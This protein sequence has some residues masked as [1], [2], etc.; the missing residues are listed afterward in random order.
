MDLLAYQQELDA[1]YRPLRQ[2][3]L[4]QNEGF[5]QL[6]EN[7]GQEMDEFALLHPREPGFALKAELHARI[8]EHFQPVIFRNSPFFFEMGLRPAEN[9]GTPARMPAAWLLSRRIG[10]VQDD[11]LYRNIRGFSKEEGGLGLAEWV[12]VFDADHHS[13]GTTRLLQTGINGLLDEVR[14]EKVGAGQAKLAYLDAVEKSCESV[15]R[16][17]S[18]FADKAEAMVDAAE[19]ARGAESLSGQQP[20]AI[21]SGEDELAYLRMIAAAARRVPAEPPRTFYEGLAMLWFL[22]EVTASIEGIGI[23]VIGSPDRQL[24]GLYLADLAGGRLTEEQARDLIAHWMLPTDVKF[25]VQDSSWPETSTCIELGGCDEAGHPLY[26]ELTRLFIQVH[27]ANHFL[28]PK[29]NCRISADATDA[30]LELIGGSVLRGHNH[31]ALLNDDV[32]IPAIIRSGKTLAEARRYVNG[33]C[34]ETIVEGVEHSAGAYYYFNMA[35][36]LDLCFQPPLASAE[37]L[38]RYRPEGD[39]KGAIPPVIREAENFEAFYSQFF[40]GLT[41]AMAAGAEWRRLLAGGWSEI[42]PCPFFSST[43]DG[44]LRNGRDYTAG[45]AKYN[46]STVAAVG[47]ATVVDSLYAVKKAVYDEKWLTLEELREAMASNWA[48]QE[49]L[50]RRLIRL[51]KFG[52]GS[53]E[54]NQL[55]TRF[56][57]EFAGF[58]R[59]LRNERG[60]F[61][62]PS[63]FVYYAFATFAPFVRATPD[64][65]RSADP[66]SQGIAPGRLSAPRSITDVFRSVSRIDFRDYPANAVLDVQLPAGSAIEPGVIASLARAFSRMGGPTLQ[67]NRVCLEDLQDAK[68][69]PERH[70]DLVVRICGLSAHF[71]RLEPNVQDEIIER[72]L[73]SVI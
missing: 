40:E 15:L 32:L 27:E 62:Q 56:C 47:L 57:S 14:G 70:Q 12:S 64:G 10:T 1:Y 9:W 23:S 42:H 65:R 16:I 31:F 18:K 2:S 5:V 53:E 52:Q 22:R 63:F 19:Q 4:E 58:V 34:Q 55:A 36:V 25:H 54:V 48:G 45:G 61:Y 11:P 69:H 72:T 20:G 13:L 30:Y 24:I 51:P 7:I 44:C 46:P 21:D 60:G 68:V 71:V 38:S 50:R 67:L 49:P 3:L 33:G 28:N 29:L 6:R 37:L 73:Y 35:G 43:L 66:L 39:S 8:A 26:N 59:G 17:A 41:R